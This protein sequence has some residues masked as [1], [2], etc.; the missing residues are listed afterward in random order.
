MNL[1]ARTGAASAKNICVRVQL[2]AT[3]KGNP[4]PLPAIYGRDKT[5]T[6]AYNSAIQYHN[7]APQLYVRTFLLLTNMMTLTLCL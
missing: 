6:T 3:D 1:T 5:L 4:Q 7:K 2:F